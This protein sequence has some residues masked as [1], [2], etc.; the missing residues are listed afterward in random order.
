MPRRLTLAPHLGALIAA[1]DGLITRAQTYQAGMTK[2]AVANRV[3]Y[4][5]WHAVLPDVFLTYAGS[6]NRRQ[7]LVA[8]LLWAGPEAAIDGRDA[9]RFH[10]VKAVAIND[11]Q[12]DVVIPAPGRVRSTDFVNIRRT[13][14]PIC[15]VR[16]ERLRY[17]DPATAVIAA[18]RR[19]SN[20]RR[21][22]AALSDALQRNVCTEHE[23]LRAHVQA[24]PRN[25]AITD[26]ALAALGS[27]ARS[28]P[29]VTFKELAEASVVLPPLLYNCLLRLPCGRK[30]SPDALA[31]DAGVVHETN[32]RRFHKR[33][34]LFEDM[35]ERH[36]LMTV[37][38]LVP[39]H[40][41]PRQLWTSGR[42]IIS[43]FETCYLRNRGQGLPPGVVILRR[44]PSSAAVAG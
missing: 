13:V 24:T 26:R 38:G 3:R 33:E 35:Q 21:V 7:M 41:T 25:A 27:G 6:L 11:T 32:G 5:G 17:V 2:H 37:A 23:L 20:E 4:A 1:Q 18:A 16:T 29:E 39:L 30:I 40:N 15:V 22:L 43:G 12:V 10:G 19:M 36:E 8:A 9:Y 34:D 31:E 14:A 44:G 28:V 42:R